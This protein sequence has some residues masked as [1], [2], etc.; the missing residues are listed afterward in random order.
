M[1]LKTCVLH[2]TGWKRTSCFFSLY[3]P[4]LISSP[5]QPNV[6]QTT[7]IIVY[8]FIEYKLLRWV[9]HNYSGSDPVIISH[10]V[11]KSEPS[12]SDLSTAG[13]SQFCHM[14]QKSSDVSLLLVR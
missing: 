7:E 14:I 8:F 6:S 10:I 1:I 2:R 4:P 12:A 3:Y 11:T 13:E 9:T 5:E